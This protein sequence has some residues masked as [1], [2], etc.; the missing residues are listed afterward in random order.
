MVNQI[1]LVS[2]LF[3]LKLL[4]Y[5]IVFINTLTFAILPFISLLTLTYEA[6]TTVD[7]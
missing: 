5:Y 7:L 1:K 6:K 3:L 4:N 2:F